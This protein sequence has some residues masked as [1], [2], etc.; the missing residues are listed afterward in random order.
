MVRV[1][2]AYGIVASL[3]SRSSQYRQVAA[4]GR[5]TGLLP[6]ELSWPAQPGQT[7]RPRLVS[8]APLLSLPPDE[9]VRRQLGAGVKLRR[10]ARPRI[11]P[12]GARFAFE[13][14][15]CHGGSVVGRHRLLG[16]SS[17][18]VA[19]FASALFTIGARSAAAYP[20]PSQAPPD[21]GWPADGLRD[22]ASV[23]PG[24]QLVS[25]PGG[26]A[27][28]DEAV[29]DV[30]T[31]IAREDNGAPS[32]VAFV[33]DRS[34]VDDFGPALE[35]AFAATRAKA[36]AGSYALISCGQDNGIWSARIEVPLTPD[37]YSI[38]RAPARVR[39][40]SNGTAIPATWMGLSKATDLAWKPAP[41]RPHVV[42]LTD[43]RPNP[44]VIGTLPRALRPDPSVRARVTSWAQK[45]RAVVHVIRVRPGPPSEPR[46]EGD[47]GPGAE[48]SMITAL[49]R[50]QRYVRASG[51]AELTGALEQS[52]SRA[53]EG[54]EPSDFV[55][56]DDQ[57]GGLDG[58]HG[59]ITR[60]LQA[61]Q[62]FSHLPE[63][64]PGT[65]SLGKWDQASGAVRFH[66]RRREDRP[67]RLEV[68]T[69]GRPPNTRRP[70]RRARAGSASVLGSAGAQ[71][72]SR[73]WR[74]LSTSWQGIPR[75]RAGLDHSKRCRR[76]DRRAVTLSL[77]APRYQMSRARRE[78]VARL[79]A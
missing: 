8:P 71:G 44:D 78:R 25:S 15:W 51:L 2:L 35:M 6:C 32:Q 75:C 57:T 67:P 30:L 50:K 1:R 72:H 40:T 60:A 16:V 54:N 38:L 33:V 55:I 43:D 36:P 23:F 70:V 66:Q 79:T 37:L 13:P 14:G 42:V 24:S 61:F 58:P 20:P 10:S 65:G 22:V 17:L 12:A 73:F 11:H 29:G 59:A 56:V 76:Y 19:A 41:S 74:P 68:A 9:I 64:S 4:R 39:W 7:I 48:I 31:A 3:I 49:F 47:D 28:L 18:A 77:L 69:E 26:S 45:W 53:A 46:S 52:L 34:F 63:P 62:L 21:E 5:S 27:F